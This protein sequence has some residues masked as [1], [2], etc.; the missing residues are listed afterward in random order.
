LDRI[1]FDSNEGTLD[2]RYGLWLPAS[3]SDLALIP[4]S[5]LQDG[6]RVIIYMPDELQIEATLKYDAARQ[7]WTAQPDLRTVRHCDPGRW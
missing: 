5:R 6:L 1:C 3:Q 4:A 7:S 2:G